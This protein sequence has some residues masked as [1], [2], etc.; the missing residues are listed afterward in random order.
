MVSPPLLPNPALILT[1]DDALVFVKARL[2]TFV[3][4]DLKKWVSQVDPALSYTTVVGLKNDTLMKP[5]PRPL[6]KLLLALGFETEL[7]QTPSEEAHN[8]KV[9][10]YQFPN[11]DAFAEFKVQQAVVVPGEKSS[12]SESVSEQLA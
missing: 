12:V 1:Y 3:H 5:A 9:F 2:S 8:A 11:S 10:A 4:G 7:M 6:Q